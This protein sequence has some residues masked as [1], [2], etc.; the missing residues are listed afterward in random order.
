MAR[1]LI[2]DDNKEVR[3]LLTAIL[4]RSGHEVVEAADGADATRSALDTGPDVIMMDIMMPGTDGWTALEALKA[5]PRTTDIPVIMLSALGTRADL[6]KARRSGAF[7]Y[8]T[9]PWSNDSVSERLNWALV[10][11]I[12]A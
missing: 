7:D 12:A 5:E 11:N 4:E 6:M 3:V 8:L 10:S 1:I 2:V 9:K